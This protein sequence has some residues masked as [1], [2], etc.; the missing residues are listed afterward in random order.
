M[1]NYGATM[2]EVLTGKKVCSSWCVPST[3]EQQLLLAVCYV[4]T[5]LTMRLTAA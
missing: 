5:A 3:L 2:T 1:N 4:G